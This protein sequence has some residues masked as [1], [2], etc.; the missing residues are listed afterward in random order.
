VEV[1]AWELLGTLWF[2]STRAASSMNG[3]GTSGV[4]GAV[5][6]ADSGWRGVLAAVW[7][8]W[9]LVERGVR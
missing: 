2:D 1:C 4:G 5:L 7:A 3:E 6:R 8:A 9:G